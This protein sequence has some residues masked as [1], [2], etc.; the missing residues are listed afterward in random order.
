MMP[1]SQLA[2]RLFHLALLRCAS[3][4]APAKQRAEWLREWDAELWHVQRVCAPADS[5]SWTA[6]REV[7]AFC[8]GA[9]QDA[10][11]LARQTRPKSMAHASLRGSAA[12]CILLLAALL[13]A[14]AVMAHLLPGV[15]AERSLSSRHVSPGLVQIQYEDKDDGSPSTISPRQYRAWRGRTQQYFE[16]FAFYRVTEESAGQKSA[17]IGGHEKAG[18]RVARASSNLFALLGLPVQFAVPDR[19]GD[20]NLLGVILSKDAWKRGFGANPHVVGST[21]RVGSQ[22]ARIVGVAPEDSWGLPGNVGAWLLQPDSEIAAGGEGYVIG[23]LTSE[24]K[25]AMWTQCV[26]ITAY[27]PG[28]SEDDLMGFS[29][30][31]WRPGSWGV[32]LFGLL[33]ALLSLPAITSVSLGDYSVC[34]HKHSWSQRLCRWS[35]LSAKIALLLPIVYFASLDLAYGYLSFGPAGAMYIQLTSS[36]SLCL[37]GFR[38]VLQDQRQRCPVCLR[39]VTNS[40]EVGLASRTFLAWNGTELMCSG[41]HTLLHVPALPTSWFSTQRWL[42][43]DPSWEFLFAGSGTGMESEAISGFSSP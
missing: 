11:C 35:F 17:S 24:G 4:L 37:F 15:R 14:S 5:L 40:A 27:G 42:Y 32:Y 38:W 31:T 18:L 20:G 2:F 25:A 7:T 19:R 6:E 10:Y 43:L 41:G 30:E 9:F 23:R 1:A 22:D 13:A 34:S 26:R 33:L 29:I 28:D 8:L 12:Q 36:F 21:I 16:G 39:T 3:L